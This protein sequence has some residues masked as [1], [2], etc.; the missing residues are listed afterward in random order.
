MTTSSS[1]P[2]YH[3]IAYQAPCRAVNACPDADSARALIRDSIADLAGKIRQSKL[4]VGPDVRL[5]VLPEYF[6]TGYPMGDTF[7]TWIAKAALDPDGPEYDALG[8]IAADNDLFLSGNVYETDAH[9]PGLYFQTSFVIDP[10]GSVILRYRRLNSMYAPTPHDV[11]DRY[12]DI[13]GLDGVFPVADTEIGRL[14]CIASEEILYPE[15]ARCLAM[16]GAEI[17]CHSSSE[18]GSPIATPKQIARQARAME[19]MAYVVS[20]N[21]AGIHGSGFPVSS[22]DGNSAIVGDKG[23][24]L[25]E[26]NTGEAMTAFY[27]IDVDAL[28]R[29]RR[30]PGMMNLLSRQRF[31]LFA[32]SYRDADFQP[33][34]SM[35]AADGTVKT[36]DRGHFTTIQHDVIAKLAKRGVI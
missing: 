28:R 33:A 17:F 26:S 18:I 14:A 1:I 5:I 11:W 19:N 9:F 30:R 23:Q 10:A 21:S 29:R 25:A 22:T 32:D 35:L 12:L 20:S 24:V 4:F 2:A 13:Y 8:K 31:A 7:E 27:E 15:I 36:V 16:R 34:G 6:L 3:A